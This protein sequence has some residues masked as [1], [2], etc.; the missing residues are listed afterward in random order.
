MMGEANQPSELFDTP[1]L[2]GVSA[3]LEVGKRL[4]A[5]REAAHLSQDELAGRLR[6]GKRQIVALET[7][8][9]S[10][11][12]GKTFVRGFVRNYANA[13]GIDPQPLLSLLDQV[14]ALAPP[15]LSLPEPTRIAL[16]TQEQ[17]AQKWD[18][19]I[20]LLGVVLVTAAVAAYFFAPEYLEQRAIKPFAK[21]TSVLS[22]EHEAL[23]LEPEAAEETPVSG[24][25]LPVATSPA[26]QSV[27]NLRLE[28]QAESWVEISKNELTLHS[29]LHEANSIHELTITPPVDIIIGRASGVRLYYQ[30]EPRPLQAN[31]NDVALVRLR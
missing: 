31:R 11:L 24:D 12:P 10:A 19:L 9:L 20:M 29:R 18:K 1:D 6:L 2:S 7:G 22:A 27:H 26:I 23:I 28:F 21:S 14:P 8:D 3:V 5:A 16:P 30:G 17:I 25:D 4:Y 15:T 13:V